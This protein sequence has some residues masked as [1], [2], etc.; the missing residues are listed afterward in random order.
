VLPV[1]F[2]ASGVRHRTVASGH[3]SLP[4]CMNVTQQPDIPDTASEEG[5]APPRAG[6]TWSGAGRA[7][8]VCALT[9]VLGF[10]AGGF[11]AGVTGLA[12]LVL[13]LGLA[14]RVLVT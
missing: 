14:L 13:A 6:V 10:R 12:A 8:M 11:Y 5:G 4:V 9:L 1:V 3:L 2:V 7:L